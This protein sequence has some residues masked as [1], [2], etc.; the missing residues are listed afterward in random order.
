MKSHP[1]PSSPQA[2]DPL[3]PAPVSHLS[4]P[5]DLRGRVTPPRFTIDGVPFLDV[6][7]IA[8]L[9]LL[10]SNHFFFSPGLSIDLPVSLPGQSEMARVD[11]VMSLSGDRLVLRSGVYNLDNILTGLQEER[12]RV[13]HDH[14][15]LLLKAP[16]ETSLASLHRIIALAR[17]A[18]FE[19][20][21]LAAHPS[22][23]SP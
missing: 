1:A 12:L 7:A 3:A 23:T 8:L 13:G 2:E 17:K 18:G 11:S 20:V 9:M 10:V 4:S 14:P 16:R 15:V 19:T 5:L 21:H 6:F 22:G